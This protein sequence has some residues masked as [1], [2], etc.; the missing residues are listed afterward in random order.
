MT[1]NGGVDIEPCDPV[2]PVMP[3][4]EGN[5][6][7][8][9]QY[10]PAEAVAGDGPEGVTYSNL[11]A[12]GGRLTA[13]A[14]LSD[15]QKWDTTGFVAPGELGWSVDVSDPAVAHFIGTYV[16]APCAP[17]VPVNPLVE[18]AV[19]TGGELIDPVVTVVDTDR[20]KYTKDGAEVS[21]GTVI[22][23][24]TLE[25]GYAWDLE[26]MPEGWTVNPENPAEATFVVELADIDCEPVAPVI[27][28][29]EGNVCV[30]GLYVAPTIV[31]NGPDGVVYSNGVA[32]DGKITITATV[33]AGFAW[34]AENMPEGW[35]I[36]EENP[37]V[38]HFTGEYV[39]APCTPVVPALPVVTPG[40]CED[41]KVVP[42]SVELPTT[43]GITYTKSGEEVPGGTVVITAVLGDGYEWG[44]MPEGWTIVNPTTATYTV[45]F[46][47]I[48]CE[49]P[50]KPTT[51]PV[52]DKL[53]ETGSGSTD[54]GI[55]M[56]LASMAGMMLAAVA[57]R[58]NA[59]KRS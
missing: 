20:I 16:E 32:A 33:E 39:E 13:T 15:G 14:T 30:G 22:V 7:E 11:E 2:V 56:I 24:A 53:P 54:A 3:T 42:P 21:G 23:T 58:M 12:E 5:V 38:A 17:V 52:V 28:T 47:T 6:C 26:E 19:C 59:F 51:P 4:V 49:L 40:V 37:G 48:T 45:T 55:S 57:L 44:E 1:F 10:F 25:D 31:V 43:P 34:D 41:D 50:E 18:D 36:D 46:D 35:T 9:G 8:G 27:P 29:I